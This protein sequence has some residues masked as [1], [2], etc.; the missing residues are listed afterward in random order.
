VQSHV[1]SETRVET[2]FKQT[3]V[4]E[5]LKDTINKTLVWEHEDEEWKIISESNR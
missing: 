5:R 1:L 4:S 2:K 3:Y